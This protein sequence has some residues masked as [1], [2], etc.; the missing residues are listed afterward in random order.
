MPSSVPAKS[1]VVAHRA[2]RLLAGRMRN[3][4]LI[5]SSKPPHVEYLS[6]ALPPASPV[7]LRGLRSD[8]ALVKCIVI[9]GVDEMQYRR[10]LEKKHSKKIRERVVAGV[11]GQGE[12]EAV[13]AA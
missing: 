8:G 4:K 5:L 11:N 1:L 10:N 12:R 2:A 13:G 7:C 9:R 3:V 6:E